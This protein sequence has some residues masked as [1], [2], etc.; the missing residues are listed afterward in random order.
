MLVI[1][2]RVLGF[3]FQ[4]HWRFSLSVFLELCEVLHRDVVGHPLAYHLLVLLLLKQN[5]VGL[6]WI[7][8]FF[9]LRGV[10]SVSVLDPLVDDF[11]FSIGD[12]AADWL[13]GGVSGAGSDLIP[14]MLPFLSLNSIPVKSIVQ[15]CLDSVKPHL[16]GCWFF[17]GGVNDFLAL[18]AS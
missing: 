9:G 6:T 3:F 15:V 11:V 18:F 10:V 4:A 12:E 5:L 16:D 1:F 13:G 8:L 14:L 2:A 17:A 7:L